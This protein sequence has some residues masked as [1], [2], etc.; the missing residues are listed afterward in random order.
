MT[1]PSS[2]QWELHCAENVLLI[3]CWFFLDKRVK[4]TYNIA[5]PPAARPV[6]KVVKQNS[7]GQSFKAPLSRPSDDFTS[8]PRTAVSAGCD[9]DSEPLGPY[10]VHRCS[11]SSAGE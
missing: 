10:G 2:P 1:R 4:K 3:M 8:S 6:F 11:V 5:V 9:W 7:A